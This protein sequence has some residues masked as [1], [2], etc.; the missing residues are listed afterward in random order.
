MEL[1]HRVAGAE[2][3]ESNSRDVQRKVAEFIARNTLPTI[4]QNCI[5]ACFSEESHEA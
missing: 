3:I 2:R 5:S 4:V 1:V